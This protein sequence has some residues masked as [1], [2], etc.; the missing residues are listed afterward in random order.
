MK[1]F[2]VQ[3]LLPVL[4]ALPACAE[5]VDNVLAQLVP[6]NSVTLIGMRMEQLKATPMFQKLIA[7]QK[8]PQLDQFERESGFN[9]LRDVRD[10]LLAN[11]GRQTILLAR[12]SFHLK[13]PPTANKFNYHGF[14][15]ISNRSR[16]RPPSAKQS[17]TTNESGFC[18]LDSTLA[19]AG[20]L[21]A[22]EAALDQYKSGNGNN[23]AALLA[24]ARTIPEN[25]QL[26]GVTTGTGN[27][28]SQNLPPAS[29][30]GVGFAPM[31]RTLQNII[32]EADLRSGLKGF[33]EG[34]CGTAQE[35]KKVSDA[36]RGIVAM[37]R[38]NTPDNQ[39]ELLRL[40]DGMKVELADRKVT[41]TV[42]IS[43]DLID[44]LVKVM[45]NPPH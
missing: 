20:P 7:Q 5:R 18:L 36:L 15:V 21:P 16:V 38:L 14:V 24:R 19:V 29:P 17:D 37:G 25:F 22:L 45:Q 41:L 3:L 42:D 43:Q 33:A 31:F 2:S 6:D 32:F 26:W 1:H 27:F 30:G 44:Q 8:L 4:V 34:F 12:G 35:A 13:L 28:I 39:P 11:N 23:A 9:P 40:W 10:V